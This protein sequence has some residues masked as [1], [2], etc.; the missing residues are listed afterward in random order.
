MIHPQ[1]HLPRREIRGGLQQRVR[2]SPCRAAW[3]RGA[4]C[5][6]RRRHGDDRVWPRQR[7]LLILLEQRSG[8]ACATQRILARPWLRRDVSL[9]QGVRRRFQS[10]IRALHSRYAGSGSLIGSNL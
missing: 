4:L 2:G 5:G 3:A 10:V 7:L 9:T 8:E 6:E 1:A